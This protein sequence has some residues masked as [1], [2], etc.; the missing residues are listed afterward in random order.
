LATAKKGVAIPHSAE[1]CCHF[2][3]GLKRQHFYL[4]WSKM[5]TPLQQNA[6]WQ[7]FFGYCHSEECGQ[8]YFHFTSSP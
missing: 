3:L 8:Q 4:E 6:E 7:H 1:K 2:T 5:A